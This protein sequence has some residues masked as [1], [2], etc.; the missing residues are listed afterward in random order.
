MPSPAKSGGLNSGILL[1]NLRAM[2][3]ANW[4]GMVEQILRIMADYLIFV[5]QV[6][7]KKPC[8]YRITT[9]FCRIF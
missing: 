7:K 3:E 9:L 4:S 5:D 8:Y 1:M 6:S 2:K